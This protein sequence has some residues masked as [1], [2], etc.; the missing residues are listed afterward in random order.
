MEIGDIGDGKA[1]RGRHKGSKDPV[2]TVCPALVS[3]KERLGRSLAL[4]G[5]T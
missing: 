2:D 3:G 4:P 5:V 1:D